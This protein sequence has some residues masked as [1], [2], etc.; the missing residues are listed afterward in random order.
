MQGGTMHVIAQGPEIT[1][2]AKV[3]IVLLAIAIVAFWRVL[4]QLALALIAVAII[5]LVG[6]GAFML[7]HAA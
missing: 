7:L 5:V 4:V 1:E 2:G 6:S 3:L